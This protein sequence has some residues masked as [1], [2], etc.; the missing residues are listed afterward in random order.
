MKTSRISKLVLFTLISMWSLSSYSQNQYIEFSL[1]CKVKVEHTSP[2]GNKKIDNDEVIVEVNEFPKYKL[3][4]LISTNDFVNKIT[5]STNSLPSRKGYE[6][7]SL[8]TSTENKYEI[9]QH[10]TY[11]GNVYRTTNLYLNR[12]NGE[13]VITTE[14][15]SPLG[16]SQTSIGGTCEKIDKKKKKF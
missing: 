14:F 11:P 16:V 6:E 1:K 3:I 9:T 5:V 10:L 12:N 13:I 4:V 15:T 8:D 7:S 2:S